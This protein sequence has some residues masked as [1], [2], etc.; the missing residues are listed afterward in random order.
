M[1]VRVFSREVSGDAGGSFLEKRVSRGAAFGDVD[2]DGDTDILVSNNSGPAELLIN[3]G[4]ENR[5]LGF[6]LTDKVSGRDL[7]GARVE[8]VLESGRILQ[9]RARTDGSYSSSHDPRVLVGLGQDEKVKSVRV[10]WPD[11]S[12]GVL[13]DPKP[14]SYNKVIFDAGGSK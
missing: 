4:N 7:L 14:N 13:L 2:N 5:W 3:H 1:S 8:V 6:E 9:R 12:K 11:G 10:F